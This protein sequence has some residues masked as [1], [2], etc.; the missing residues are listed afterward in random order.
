VEEPKKEKTH[1]DD[2]ATVFGVL[3]SLNGEQIEALVIIL[4]AVVVQGDKSATLASYYAGI[5]HQRLW[6]AKGIFS[7]ELLDDLDEIDDLP[8]AQPIRGGGYV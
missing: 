6:A 2:I 7:P 5:F 8:F 1:S 4:D 3:D